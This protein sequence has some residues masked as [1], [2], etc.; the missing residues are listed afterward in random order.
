MMIRLSISGGKWITIYAP[1]VV[2][3]PRLHSTAALK[4]ASGVQP[5]SKGQPDVFGT[6]NQ[7]KV[8]TGMR[9]DELRALSPLQSPSA[10]PLTIP[11]QFL[12][13]A[14]TFHSLDVSHTTKLKF[15]TLTI[16][17]SFRNPFG[18]PLTDLS[19]VLN[20]AGVQMTESSADPL[21][22]GAWWTTSKILEAKNFPVVPL[23]SQ[24]IA[25][26]VKAAEMRRS[27]SYALVD[28]S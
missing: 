5:V 26:G 27:W 28:F 1:S 10:L 17:L 22:P 8:K 16:S 25:A 14:E 3:Q 21:A 15:D 18:F 23:G 4:T 2:I 9:H 19:L 7:W 6:S 13:K 11:V 20:V 24:M 12:Q